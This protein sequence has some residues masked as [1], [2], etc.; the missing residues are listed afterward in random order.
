[1]SE[2]ESKLVAEIE[3]ANDDYTSSLSV[4]KF[5][6]LIVDCQKSLLE[7]ENMIS[8]KAGIE[9]DSLITI[10]RNRGKW[11][12]DES[13]KKKRKNLEDPNIVY[14][15][16]RTESTFN[17]ISKFSMDYRYGFHFN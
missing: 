15:E 7:I 4:V 16:I 10:I 9:N 11:I 17:A 12:R 6:N 13:T 3:N 2:T 5:L 1:M 14:T 8:R